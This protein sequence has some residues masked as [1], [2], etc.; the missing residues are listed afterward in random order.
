VSV[1]LTETFL[2]RLKLFTLDNYDVRA[3]TLALVEHHAVP[4]RWF[5]IA[6]T[7]ADGMFRR[8][9]LKLEPDLLYRVARADCLGR[10]GDFKPEAEE[11]FLARVRA[12]GIEERAPEPLLMGRHLLALGLRPG[13]RIGA[14]TRAVYERQ[15][16][17]D[18]TKI[19]EAVEAA[20][21]L[22]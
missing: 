20:K 7:I 8:L 4:Y 6:E 18:V 16:D 5:R 11:W 21:Q 22:I 3:Q 19:E 17:G 12:L 10:A 2:E 15:L 13:P 1:A 9:A 14:I